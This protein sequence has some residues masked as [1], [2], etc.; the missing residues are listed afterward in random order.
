METAPA[1]RQQ[2]VSLKERVDSVD[3]LRGF[4]LFGI[5][6]INITAFKSPGTPPGLVFEGSWWDRV[7][8]YGIIT[9]IDSKFFTLFSFLFGLGFSLQLFSAERQGA[10]F[11]RRFSRR[12]VALALFGVLHIILFWDGDILLLYA[13]VGFILLFFRNASP[14]TLRR[15]AV[16]LLVSVSAFFLLV[17]TG[18]QV[19]SRLPA[20]KAGLESTNKE[21]AQVFTKE[22]EVT[23]RFNL[24]AS[25]GELLQKRVT[26]YG[27]TF[28]LLFTRIPTVL[29]MFLLGLYVG[30]RDILRNIDAHLRLL[31]SVRFWGWV[32]GLPLS[33]IITFGYTNLP[34]LYGLSVLFFNQTFA[35]P[36]L[37]MAYAATLLLLLR[38]E[39]WQRLLRPLAFSGRM[40]LT[41]YLSQSLV[42]ALLFNGF[43]LGL[44]A[45]VT[46]VVSFLIVVALYT[47]QIL[48]SRLWLKYFCFGP[49]EWLWRCITYGQWQPIR[50]QVSKA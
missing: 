45:K 40:A 4:A 10:N 12:L 17:F 38:R 44:I 46:P 8:L 28:L 36:I 41:N 37:S 48:L 21:F 29:A 31:R 43:G 1:T 16:G 13:I 15:W 49:L 24:T 23:N 34:P 50:Y 11:I 30:R 2:A 6:L 47:L 18:L 35:G 33:L 22:S 27:T 25:Y 42:C 20:T 26:G 3:I 9:F 14:K 39:S 7:Y 32:I 5:L 19:A